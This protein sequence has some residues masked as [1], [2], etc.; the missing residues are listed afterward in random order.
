MMIAIEEKS[1]VI[2]KAFAL[3]VLLVGIALFFLALPRV[4]A[5]FNY[6]PVDAVIE[7]I[8]NRES[9]DDEKFAELIEI[10]QTSISIDDNPHYWEGLSGLFLYQA[11]KDDLSKE[12]GINWL[13]QAKHSIEQS[14]ARSPA[15]ADLWYSLSVVYFL[16]DLPPEQ[17]VKMLVMSIITDPNATGI[18][19]QRLNLCLQYFYLFEDDDI[20]LLR[21]QVLTAWSVSSVDFLSTVANAQNMSIIWLLLADKDSSVLKEMVETLEK[22]H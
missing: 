14:L 10:A 21:A 15:N 4:R 17:M 5:A 13:K 12:A 16:L 22:N 19:M 11:Q 8:N 6:L 3:L 20:D 1:M 9:L 2:K 18:L 7:K